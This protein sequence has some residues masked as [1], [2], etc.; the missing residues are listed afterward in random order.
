M[1][2]IQIQSRRYIGAKT[3]LLAPILNSFKDSTKVVDMFAGTGVVAASLIKEGKQV[4]IN[5]MLYSNYIVYQ[6]FFGAG[7]VNE[8]KLIT[9]I[10]K[11]NETTPTTDNYMNLNFGGKYFEKEVARKI[12]WIREEIEVIDVNEQEKYIL[13]SSLLYYM[14]KYANTVGHYEM[15]LKNLSKNKYKLDFKM[16]LIDLTLRDKGTEIYNLDANILSKTLSAD[17]D[18]YLDPPYNNRQYVSFYHMWENVA[19]WEKPT[20]KFQSMKY[21]RSGEFSEYSRSKANVA[22]TQLLLD[23]DDNQ[24]VVISYNNTADNSIKH[25]QMLNISSNNNTKQV[26]LISLDHKAFNSGKTS[27]NN[28]LEYLFVIT[29]S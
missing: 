6:G 5:D 26:N 13:I 24:K 2:R 10:N 4:A 27:I 18:V 21:D 12:G 3:K 22:M 16:G 11:F 19:R 15:F 25:D 9:I 17:Y 7:T 8:S 29:K 28:H 14:D 1:D 23:L 20:L